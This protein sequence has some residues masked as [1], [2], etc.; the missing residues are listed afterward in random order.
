[1]N[2]RPDH[3]TERE[4]EVLAAIRRS[5]I[6]RGEALSVRELGSVLGMSSSSSVAYHLRNLVARGALVRDGHSWR[7]CRLPR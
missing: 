7:T 6:D 5:I 4:E 3:L 1:M 2:R